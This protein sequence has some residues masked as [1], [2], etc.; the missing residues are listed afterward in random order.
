MDEDDRYIE[1]L[2][3]MFGL[4][5][6][7]MWAKAEKNSGLAREQLR[8]NMLAEGGYFTQAGFDVAFAELPT[9]PY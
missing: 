2:A 8:G 7:E 5:V 1:Q 9:G 3:E 4:A 6:E